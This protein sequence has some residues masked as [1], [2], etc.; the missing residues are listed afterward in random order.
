MTIIDNT[1]NSNGIIVS[2]APLTVESEKEKWF[3]SRK[4][5]LSAN[6]LQGLGVANDNSSLKKINRWLTQ[7]IRA[8]QYQIILLL[9]NN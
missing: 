8:L 5:A 2:S 3:L 7:L 4:W 1:S 6:K 9:L